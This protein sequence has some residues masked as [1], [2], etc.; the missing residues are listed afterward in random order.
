M[1]LK[2]QLD[3]PKK[4]GKTS[5]IETKFDKLGNNVSMIVTSHEVD[6]EKL[7]KENNM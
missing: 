5:T 6:E 7:A 2:K 1:H 4:G 3:S